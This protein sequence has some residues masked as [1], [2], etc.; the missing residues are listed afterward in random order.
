MYTTASV[1]LLYKI[2]NVQFVTSVLE[3]ILQFK[4]QYQRSQQPDFETFLM[5][6]LCRYLS[7][8]ALGESLDMEGFN[9]LSTT[10][11]EQQ[12]IKELASFRST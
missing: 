10:D 3:M 2:W 5:V 1:L 12:V 4:H 6:A 8:E 7:F 11:N 9:L